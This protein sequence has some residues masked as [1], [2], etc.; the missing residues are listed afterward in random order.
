MNLTYFLWAFK[1]LALVNSAVY[2]VK[3]RSH[4]LRQSNHCIFFP[5]LTQNVTPRR[6][7]GFSLPGNQKDSRHTKDC[8]SDFQVC[9]EANAYNTIHRSKN[10][11][12]GMIIGI[13]R[14]SHPNAYLHQVLWLR[15]NLLSHRSIKKPQWIYSKRS[16]LVNLVYSL[17]VFH[18]LSHSVHPNAVAKFK[19]E[20]WLWW[21]R[22]TLMARS[23]NSDA[24]AIMKECWLNWLSDQK[25]QEIC[26]R[27]KRTKRAASFAVETSGKSSRVALMS[28]LLAW[29]AADI[30]FPH[31]LSRFS[32]SYHTH[33]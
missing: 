17:R 22:A 21:D 16:Y 18:S 25:D 11:R 1:R 5:C 28:S 9:S 8:P 2:W 12:A 26:K 10:D 29:C 14:R 27:S 31:S 7:F 19:L 20:K 6:I 13:E 4:T 3:S 33:H 30:P 24:E 23:G 15:L 32:F